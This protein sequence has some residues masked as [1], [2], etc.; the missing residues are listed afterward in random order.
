MKFS[1]AARIR[2][3]IDDDATTI[4]LIAASVGHQK[5]ADR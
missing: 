2:Y 1:G 4:W 3:A 5:T